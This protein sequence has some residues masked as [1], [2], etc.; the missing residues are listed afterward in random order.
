M[1]PHQRRTE[2]VRRLQARGVSS[3][4]DL[5]AEF[6]VSRSTIRRDLAGLRDGDR[7]RRVYGGAEVDRGPGFD[8]PLPFAQVASVDVTDKRL[9]AERAAQ[10]VDDG[11][12][13]LIDVGT[14]ARALAEALRGRQ[15]TVI[16]SNLA[17][18]DV[19]RDDPDVELVLLGGVVRRSYHSTVGMLTQESLRRV[20]ADHAFL[21]GSGL[22]TNGAVL[23]NTRV[24]VPSKR[25]M[26]AAAAHTV[27]LLDRHKFPGSGALKVCDIGELDALVTN[28]GADTVTLSRV[29]FAGVKVHLAGSA[30]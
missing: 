2:I 11:E 22:R 26:I 7:V 9:V 16:T 10:M 28:K 18:F 4:H 6:A 1:L 21:G 25:A 29:R 30:R 20:Q 5:A 17:A 23:D 27:L 15:I 13:V 14:T 24:E 3:V 8:E 12:V 19:L